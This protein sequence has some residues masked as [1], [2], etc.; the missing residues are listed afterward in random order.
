M[1]KDILKNSKNTIIMIT[2]D[3]Y[4]ID[5]CDLKINLV[6]GEITEERGKN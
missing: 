1:L 4:L 2:H 5:I 6:E 3:P